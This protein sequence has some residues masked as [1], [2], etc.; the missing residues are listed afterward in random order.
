[1]YHAAYIQD[2]TVGQGDV[3]GVIRPQ[4]LMWEGDFR[5][6]VEGGRAIGCPMRVPVRGAGFTSDD[7]E[8]KFTFTMPI[9]VVG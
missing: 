8:T 4:R 1:M 5:A 9:E 6:K 7:G 3:D 2:G